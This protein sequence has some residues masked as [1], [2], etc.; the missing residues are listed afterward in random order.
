MFVPVFISVDISG[1]SATPVIGQQFT[2]TCNVLGTNATVYQWSKDGVANSESGQTLSFTRLSLCDA[3]EYTCNITFNGVIY[4]DT[5]AIS[6]KSKN[7]ELLL[8]LLIKFSI[9]TSS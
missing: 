2:L 9:Q 4:N 3:G 1:S 5:M 8:R 7:T 6:I